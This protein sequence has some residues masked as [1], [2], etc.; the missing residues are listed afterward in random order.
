MS[1]G[2]TIAEILP[3]AAAIITAVGAW[4]S[5]HSAGAKVDDVHK[6]VNSNVLAQEARNDQ[7][8]ASLTEADKARLFQI[9]REGEG[10]L[11]LSDFYGK[12][13]FGKRFGEIFLGEPRC[14]TAL[15]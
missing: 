3:G 7:L 5:S 11:D 4:R 14:K 8:T 12:S 10:P 6:L 1:V 13:R 15:Q 9:K 2:N